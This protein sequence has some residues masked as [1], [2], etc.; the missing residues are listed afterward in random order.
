MVI[1]SQNKQG[2]VINYEL[3]I[4]FPGENYNFFRGENC[5]FM[6]GKGMSPFVIIVAC[7]LISLIVDLLI[8]SFILIGGNV[9]KVIL[10]PLT[11]GFEVCNP[12]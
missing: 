10:L 5:L 1:G 8:L 3:S 4:V 11:I 7:L 12:T 2:N 9:N 6:E